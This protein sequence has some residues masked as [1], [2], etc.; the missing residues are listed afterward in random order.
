MDGR[1][2]R[3]RMFHAVRFE[4]RLEQH[5]YLTRLNRFAY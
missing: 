3:M 2:L 4:N 1:G 5:I